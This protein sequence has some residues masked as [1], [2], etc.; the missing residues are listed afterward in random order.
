[1][2]ISARFVGHCTCWPSCRTSLPVEEHTELYVEAIPPSIPEP[3]GGFQSLSPSQACQLALV[4]HK[5]VYMEGEEITARVHITAR[6]PLSADLVR[7]VLLRIENTR[8]G[9][10][11]YRLHR[12]LGFLHGHIPRRA[13]ARRRG[14]ELC[15]ARRRGC[16]G[17]TC[18]LWHCRPGHF[19]IDAPH[20]LSLATKLWDARGPGDLEGRGD[21]LALG[22]MPMC[23]PCMK[24]WCTPPMPLAGE[25]R[26]LPLPRIVARSSSR[27]V[28]SVILC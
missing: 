11:P 2:A 9:G 14:H 6:E 18:A 21:P 22:A 28:I 16:L 17:R 10:Q 23:A 7:V 19:S 24:F 26:P 8:Q 27:F 5:A 13:L 15:V 1:M 12:R 20:P 25:V 3:T 4:L